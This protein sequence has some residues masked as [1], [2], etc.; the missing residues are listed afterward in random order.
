M[1]TDG[2]T[3]QKRQGCEAPD[4]VIGKAKGKRRG[5]GKGTSFHP[6]IVDGVNIFVRML[7]LS[8]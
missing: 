2:V 1:E 6:N 8:M 7:C 3:L 4:G 5:Q